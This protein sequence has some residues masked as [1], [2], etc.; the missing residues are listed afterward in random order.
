[1]Q[2]KGGGSLALTWLISF[3]IFFLFS[4]MTLIIMNISLSIFIM[5]LGYTFNLE[6]K[7]TKS[8]YVYYFCILVLSEKMYYSHVLQIFL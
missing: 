2:Q 8:T 7:E 3:W 4:K 5:Y 1:M 6:L